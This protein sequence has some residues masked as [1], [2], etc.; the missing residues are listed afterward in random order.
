MQIR[1]DG[2]TRALARRIGVVLVGLALL[3]F[4]RKPI[5][6]T[7]GLA[8]GAAVLAFLVSPL[9]NRFEGRLGR[10]LSSLLALLCVA[11]AVGGLAA[12]MLPAMV[13]QARSLAGVLPD[14]VGQLSGWLTHVREWLSLRFPGISLPEVRLDGI[15]GIVSGLAGGTLAFAGSAAGTASRLSLM[16][17]LAFFFLCDRDRLLLRLELLTPCSHRRTAVRMGGAVLRECRL[18]LQAQLMVSACVGALSAAG[19]ALIGVPSPL[20]LGGVVGLFNMVP[21]FGPFIGGV[22]AV[23]AALGRGWQRAALAAGALIVVQQLD[24]AVI[25]PRVMGSL[26]GFSPAAVLLAI[27]AGAAFGGVAGMLAALPAMMSARTVYRVFV[28]SRENI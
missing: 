25:S 22:P 13:G 16:V 12:F 8:L 10:P 11:V 28:Q 20:V 27:Y 1:L 2:R 21:Y 15:Q 17:M 19:L 5:L 14:S 7:A 4:L 6:R 23:L 3:W 9:A 18:Y 24:S 26:T